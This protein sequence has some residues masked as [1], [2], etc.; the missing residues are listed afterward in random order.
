MDGWMAYDVTSFLTVFQSY[1]DDGWMIM[2][3]SVQWNLIYDGK[4]PCL[5]GAQTQDC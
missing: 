1:Q 4:D 2:K 5:T 3:G